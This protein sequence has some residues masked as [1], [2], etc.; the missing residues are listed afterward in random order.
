[1]QFLE[2]KNLIKEILNINRNKNKKSRQELNQ[3]PLDLQ[4]NA[5]LLSYCSLLFNLIFNFRYSS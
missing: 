3:R 1:M 4:T 5:L 2:Y